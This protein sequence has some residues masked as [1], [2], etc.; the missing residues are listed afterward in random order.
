M[1]RIIFFIFS[2]FSLG[3]PFLS[4]GIIDTRSAGYSKTWVDW[5]KEGDGFPLKV[6]RSYSSRSLFNGIFGFG[7]CSN[8]E[9]RMDTLPDN[10]LKGIEC[11]GGLETYYYPKG[12]AVDVGLQTKV[13]LEEMKKRKVKMSAKDLRK[14]EKDLLQ[15]QT[16][17]S[18]FMQALGVRG[19]ARKGI[20]YYA[21]GR[22]N[23]YVIPLSRGFRRHLPNGIVE[24]FDDSG[25]LIKAVDRNGNFIEIS[26]KPK[27]VLVTDNR[28]RRFRLILEDG[29][30]KTA[31][32]GKKI[33]ASYQHDGEDLKRIKN[34]YNE[35]FRHDYDDFHNLTKTTYPDG[36]TEGLS[37]NVK[38][39]WVVKFTDRRGCVESYGF[40]QNK[41]N[42]DHYFSTVE[43]RCGRR[44]VNRSKYEFWNRD[45]PKGKG[46]Y[47][48]RART[49][50][51]GRLTA[52]VIYHPKF[53]SPISFY[54]NGVRINRDY[55][56]N[57][58]LKEK[59]SPFLLV[60]Y[61]NYHSKC[62]RPELVEMYYKNPSTKKTV[63]TENITF[64]YR[65]NCELRLAKKSDDEWVKVRYD[66]QGRLDYMEDQSRK[67]VT[68]SWH[69]TLEQPEVIKRKGVGSV[70]VIYN[71]KGELVD[72]K[73]G[74][75]GVDVM[76]QVTS[77]FNSFLQT[78]S[79]VAEEMVIL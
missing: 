6:E 67:V 77:V 11:G 56:A 54:R 65:P 74:K 22:S 3:F 59:S 8:F 51:N 10:S 20:K 71:E 63:R 35:V 40:G 16:L 52:D 12:A 34:A 62:R 5:K 68:I 50:V 37:Y 9:T 33:V 42:S 19:K 61:K 39:D 1:E 14:L 53:G 31:K 18:D 78:I 57:G 60:K 30:V 64:K 58:F 79:P 49:R 29:K 38:K 2:V 48:H 76:A 75:A 66:K 26:W 27:E 17:R 25:R 13:V 7:W 28:G 73:A 72:L 69:K 47:L 4:A 36:T 23:E 45:R 24:T 32:Y 21:N 41:K 46:K 15:S 55:Y 44:I 70:R 43:K